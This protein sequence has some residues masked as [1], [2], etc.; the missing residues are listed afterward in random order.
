MSEVTEEWHVKGVLH[1]YM[2]SNLKS[3]GKLCN[4]S[5]TVN[6]LILLFYSVFAFQYKPSKIL[7]EETSSV[8]T[9]Q[10]S[11]MMVKI[12]KISFLFF[13]R[14]YS[15]FKMVSFEFICLHSWFLYL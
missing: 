6:C 15:V 3:Y 14:F 10:C 9:G 13:E 5:L 11:K 8:W 7:Q 2:Y 12:W 1:G 4:Y